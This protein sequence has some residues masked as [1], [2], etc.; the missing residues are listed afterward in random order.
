MKKWRAL[1]IFMG[2]MTV[3]LTVP[4]TAQA[5]KTLKVGIVDAYSGGAAPMAIDNLNG[6]KMAINAINAKGGVNGTK[7]EFVTR[8]DKFKPDISLAMAK[9]LVMKEKVDILVGTISSA[10]ALAVSEF[11]KKE[12]IPF[13]QYGR[14]ERKN[15]GRERPPLCFSDRR[16]YRDGRQGGGTGPGKETIR[17]V[18]DCGRRH[19]VR[20][21]DHRAQ[22]GTT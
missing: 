3:V 6:F 1:S 9:E 7:I 14:Q 18:L 11:A 10:A 2:F 15:H 19:G 22:S 16:E 20:P 12:K 4:V 13:H 5:A 21:R 17:Q 8:D